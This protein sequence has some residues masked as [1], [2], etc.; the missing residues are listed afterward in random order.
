M[1][2]KS[3]SKQKRKSS[4][5]FFG[6]LFTKVFFFFLVGVGVLSVFPE[7]GKGAWFVEPG[8]VAS[9]GTAEI[10][11]DIEPFNN[12]S[13]KGPYRGLG[14]RV[15]VGRSFPLPFLFA[16]LELSRITP[17]FNPEQKGS[18]SA[19]SESRSL[20]LVF[21]GDISVLPGFGFQGWFTYVPL[22]SQDIDSKGTQP[23]F[24]TTSGKGIRMGVGKSV[25]VIP[26][27]RAGLEYFEE[28]FSDI[29]INGNKI[30]G[31]KLTYKGMNLVL[32][33]KF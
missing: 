30:H 21:G 1:T 32:S 6:R 12:L 4:P 14:L 20:G 23:S 10:T 5:V 26:L 17:T 11:A 16:A 33:L 13:L 2:F 28:D 31:S 8:I 3:K 9:L 25:S 24:K 22:I 19:T 7:W 27:L 15:R 18:Y 29:E